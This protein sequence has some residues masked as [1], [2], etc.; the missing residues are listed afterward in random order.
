MALP[1]SHVLGSTWPLVLWPSTSSNQKE[2]HSH[3]ASMASG[4]ALVGQP[5]LECCAMV[6]NTVG[7]WSGLIW[8][9]LEARKT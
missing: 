2:S 5:C 8:I 9:A 3:S 7:T 4:N 1:M 6:C